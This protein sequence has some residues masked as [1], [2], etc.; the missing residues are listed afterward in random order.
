VYEEPFEEEVDQI[1][2]FE[3]RRTRLGRDFLLMYYCPLWYI[4]LEKLRVEILLRKKGHISL[5]QYY[6]ISKKTQMISL[7]EL[8][9]IFLTVFLKS[10]F[11]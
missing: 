11:W 5:D 7:F 2:K 8:I 4:G 10:Y 6:Y 3:F 9:S 1:H